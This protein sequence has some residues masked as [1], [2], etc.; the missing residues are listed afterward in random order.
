LVFTLV[1]PIPRV[2]WPGK[3]VDA[4]FDLPTEVGLKGVSLSTSII[5]EWYISYGWFTVLLGG[6]LHGRLASTANSLRELGHLTGNPIVYS[7]AVMVLLAGMRSMQD[8]VL[9][10]YALVAWWAVSR[11]VSTGQLLPAHRM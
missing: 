4:G 6:W 7:L 5:G 1:R 11:Y 2:F 9:M 10:S 3:P 8:L